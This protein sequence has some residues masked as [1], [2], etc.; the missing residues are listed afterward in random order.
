MKKFILNTE[1]LEYYFTKSFPTLRTGLDK[2][3]PTKFSSIR[4][5]EYNIILNKIEK[6]HYEFTR[7]KKLQLPNDRNVFIPTIRDRL[8]LDYLKDCLSYKYKIKYR[9]R[10]E[11]IKMIKYKLSIQND[12]YII[13]LDLK[14]F[15]NT[16]PHN[17]LL[18]KLKKGSLL[19]NSEYI[20]VKNILKKVNKGI[21]QG[22]P[23]SNPLSEIFLED[24][25][26]QMKKIDQKLNYYCRYVDDILLIFNGKLNISEKNE[27]KQKVE[28][29]I[30]N[31]GLQNNNSK[32]R[33]TPVKNNVSI[34]FQ[35]LGYEFSLDKILLQTKISKNKI[36]R[37]KQ[38]I[39]SCFNNYVK[40]I[41]I[42]NK[43]SI[44]LLIERLNF[45]TKNQ[46][47]IRKER[48]FDFNSNRIHFKINFIYS[49]FQESYKYIDKENMLELCTEID[50]LIKKR[51]QNLKNIITQNEAKRIL[52]SISMKRNY[53]DNKIIAISKFNTSD[54][55]KRIKFINPTINNSVLYD[56]SFNELEKYYFQLLNLNRI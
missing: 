27:I 35:Y 37:L 34:Q 8:V 53:L 39:N 30:K 6:N 26:L 29:L 42:K 32:F 14:N 16:I 45:L 24:F 40:D 2:I 15:F 23:I 13:R 46:F 20:L 1:L 31:Y 36:D 17:K 41:K 51:I 52:Y 19:S 55:I 11:I 43:D 48:K 9:D 54:Y 25:D 21:P 5:S 56:L 18:H 3:T 28:A 50:T 12:Y 4:H 7:L 47:I 49:G 10:N 22:L 33:E 44:N 38:K